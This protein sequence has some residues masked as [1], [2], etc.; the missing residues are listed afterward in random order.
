MKKNIIRAAAVLAV[1]VSAFAFKPFASGSVFCTSSCTTGNQIAYKI[2]PSG[3]VTQPCPGSVQPYILD[4]N[5]ICQPT[6]TGTKF[7]T[8]TDQGN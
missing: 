4:Q 6:A 2:D 3:L 8:V 5:S 7:K 1:V